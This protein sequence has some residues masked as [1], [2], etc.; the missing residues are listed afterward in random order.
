MF[1]CFFRFIISSFH[2]FFRFVVLLKLERRY[3]SWFDY[4]E[5]SLILCH[6]SFARRCCVTTATNAK[7][8]PEVWK[9]QIKKH[10]RHVRTLKDTAKVHKNP[11]SRGLAKYIQ[12]HAQS[13]Q[14]ILLALPFAF[15]LFLLRLPLFFPSF[16][17][18]PSL[19]ISFSLF[20]PP[21]PFPHFLPPPYYSPLPSP[22]PFWHS[23]PVPQSSPAFSQ[24]TGPLPHLSCG[25]RMWQKATY[26]PAVVHAPS[27]VAA[28]CLVCFNYFYRFIYLVI[29][30]L[31]EQCFFSSVDL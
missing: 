18:P 28:E 20:T 15:P 25:E 10:P 29:Y 19:L 2:F 16:P 7:I 12:E 11:F 5:G 17:T 24:L 22:L 8:A 14:N 21:S 27:K 6:T 13:N 26:R 3:R 1:V 23:M 9:D 31:G 30:S 4:K